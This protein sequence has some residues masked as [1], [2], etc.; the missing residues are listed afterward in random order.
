MEFS[1]F[2]FFNPSLIFQGKATGIVE[3]FF[4]AGT[5]FGP[6]IGGIL[7]DAGGFKLPFFFLGGFSLLFAAASTLMFKDFAEEKVVDDSA[8]DEENSDVKWTQILKAPGQ[9]SY[10][11]H[12]SRPIGR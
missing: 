3:A 6:S 8:S 5:M 2:L 7:Y 12:F 9:K 4:G 11:N 1:T 10:D